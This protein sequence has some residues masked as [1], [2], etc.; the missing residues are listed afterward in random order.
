MP[1]FDSAIEDRIIVAIA[2]IPED[3]IC[4]LTTLAT[5]FD[6]PYQQLTRR[7]HGN[8]AQTTKGGLNARLSPSQS[9]ALIRRIK[10]MTRHAFPMGRKQ[11]TANAQWIL[12]LGVGGPVAP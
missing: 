8:P 12:E 3:G 4:N 1:A 6:V 9:Y 10:T 2:S 11:I 7:Y 5:Q